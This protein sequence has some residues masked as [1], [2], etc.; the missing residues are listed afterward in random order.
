MRENSLKARL[1][2]GEATVGSWVS[3]AHPT[4]AEVMAHAGFD[5]LAIDMEHGIIGIESVLALVQAINTTPVAPIV[6]V[7]WNEP[8]I[9][10]QVLE[11]GPA[12]LIMPQVNTAAEA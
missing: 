5:W 12:G 6:R 1:K 4:V 2:A 3:V 10:K 7:P 9:V 11:T 8:V